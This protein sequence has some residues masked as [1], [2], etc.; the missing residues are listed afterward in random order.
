M[1]R[2]ILGLTSW[3]GGILLLI[4]VVRWVPDFETEDLAGVLTPLSVASW[5]SIT[6]LA[7]LLLAEILVRPVRALG[8]TLGRG[9]AFWLGWVRS[10]CNQLVPLTGMA[11]FAGFMRRRAGMAWGRVA[12]LASPQFLLAITA[13]GLFGVLAVAS[14]RDSL[15]NQALP[16]LG[17]FTGAAVGAMLLILRGAHGLRFAPAFLRRRLDSA[18]QALVL[19]A[20]D[21][22]LLAGV[23]GLHF[24]TVCLRA[25]RLWLLFASAHNSTPLPQVLLMVAISEIGFLVQ[26]TPGGM[27]LREGALVGTA[28]FLGLDTTAVAGIALADRLL[29]LALTATLAAPSFWALHHL[30]RRD[31]AEG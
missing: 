7:R 1:R 14:A 25:A 11:V 20:E 6:F 15:G 2:T 5:V 12:A 26:L 22:S 27:G 9:E 8:G 23:L 4:G 3:I 21:H 17:I 30:P 29:I 13:S 16:L 31:N 28:A 10:F 24:S 19:L 18:H